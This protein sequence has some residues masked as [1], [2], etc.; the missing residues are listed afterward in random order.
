[1]VAAAEV[2]VAMGVGGMSLTRMVLQ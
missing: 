1:V 2:A